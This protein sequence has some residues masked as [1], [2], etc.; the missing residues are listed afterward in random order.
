M[1][2][3][4]FRLKL[5]QMNFLGIGPLLI[6]FIMK[7]KNIDSLEQFIQ[8]AIDGGARLV[9]C[10]MSMDMMGIQKEELI[11]GIEIGG[12]AAYLSAAEQADNNLFI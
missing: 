11:D 3:G 8:N 6:R 10:Q 9:A 1:P 7:K 5:S 2:R 4:T 12:V